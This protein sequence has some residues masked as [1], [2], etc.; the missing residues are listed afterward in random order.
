MSMPLD[1]ILMREGTRQ[2]ASLLRQTDG[3]WSSTAVIVR[4]N[5]VSVGSVQRLA[6]VIVSRC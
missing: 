5:R 4:D 6:R 1:G 2:T 3:N